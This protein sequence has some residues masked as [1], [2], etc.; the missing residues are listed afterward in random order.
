MRSALV[1]MGGKSSRLGVKKGGIVFNGKPLSRWAIE[2]MNKVGG[3]LIISVSHESQIPDADFLGRE[4]IIAQDEIAGSGPI[5]GLLSGLRRA[6]HEYV[7]VAPLDSPLINPELYTML[8]DR[9]KGHDGAVPRIDGYWEPLHAVY[10]KRTMINA[11]EEQLK[12]NIRQI[13][14][15]YE[16]LDIAEIEKAEIEVVDPSLLSLININ[17][18]EDFNRLSEDLLE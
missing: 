6:S 15:T 1:L 12:V 9:A 11:I 3:E 8:F 10:R 2:A 7:A 14:R 17:T 4:V 18:M 5:G 13:N 16:M